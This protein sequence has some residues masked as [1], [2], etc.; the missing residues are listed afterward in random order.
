MS[1]AFPIEHKLKLH[2]ILFTHILENPGI[3]LRDL[4]EDLMIKHPKYTK[5]KI[6]KL[7]YS[8][9]E[10]GFVEI[11]QERTLFICPQIL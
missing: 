8:D 10:M 3:S 1:F 9:I 6:Q 4:F 7:L 5:R 2:E 11:T